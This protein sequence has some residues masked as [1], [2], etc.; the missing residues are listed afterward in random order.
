MAP[1]IQLHAQNLGDITP[2]CMSAY[3]GETIG[4][5]RTEPNLRNAWN[6]PNMKQLRLNMLEG[7]ESAMCKNCYSDQQLG[8]MERSNA[9][10]Q[11]LRHITSNA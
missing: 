11:R 1:W 6:S 7:R 10:Q 5:L 3:Q 2:C 9:V 4:S 8:K